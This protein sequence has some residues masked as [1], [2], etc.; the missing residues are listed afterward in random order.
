MDEEQESR[1]ASFTQP[2]IVADQPKGCVLLVEDDRSVRRYLEVT[3]QRAGY[4]VIST[5]DGLEA[6]KLALSSPIDALVTDAIMPYLSGQQLA[7]FVR[8]NAKLAQVPI[9][10]LTGQENKAAAA[11]PDDLID[12]FLCKPVKAEELTNCLA[13]LL[14]KSHS[15]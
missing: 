13:R 11:L 14:Q 7:R 12:A 1:P 3:L 15:T 5:K 6:M 2:D 4:E 8:S 10:L 9:V